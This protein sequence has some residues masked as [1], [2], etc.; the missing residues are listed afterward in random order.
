M[1]NFPPAFERFVLSLYQGSRQL[2]PSV[3]AWFEHTMRNFLNKNERF[4]LY[5]YLGQLLYGSFSEAELNDI[6]ESIDPDYHFVPT[7]P[8]LQMARDILAKIMA[9]AS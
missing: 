1:N 7:G 6:Y 4:Q 3:P 9:E 8:I 5:D 2:Y